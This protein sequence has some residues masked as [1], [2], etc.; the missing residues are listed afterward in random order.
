V[1]CRHLGPFS[2]A[3]EFLAFL[4]L[5]CG[6]L[7]DR[8]ETEKSSKSH[9]WRGPSAIMP[10]TIIVVMPFQESSRHAPRAAAHVTRSVTATKCERH[11]YH[12]HLAIYSQAAKPLEY[13][14]RQS[15]LA[16]NVR[17]N[18]FAASHLGPFPPAFQKA[19]QHFGFPHV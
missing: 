5:P 6:W 11:H 16:A 18:T 3:F 7:V 14:I 19:D 10:A 15:K 13:E 8:F 12:P 9:D 4:D 2:L 1:H 17:C